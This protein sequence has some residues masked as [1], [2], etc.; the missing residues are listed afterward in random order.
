MPKLIPLFPHHNHYV[1]VFGGS[2]AD[3]LAKPRS[4][5]ETYNDLDGQLYEF[6]SAI[7]NPAQRNVLL[8][9]LRHTPICQ[10]T[11]LDALQIVQSPTTDSVENAW[12]FIVVSQ[13]GMCL[14]HP[15]LLAPRNWRI[16]RKPHG[17]V[18]GWATLPQAVT[19]AAERF[20]VVQIADESWDRLIRKCDTP[21]T[22]FYL[23]PSYYP[24]TLQS[25]RS[26]YN[27][28]LSPADHAALVA[29]L[30]EIDGY[31]IL[32]GYDNDLYRQELR[33]WRRVAFEVRTSIELSGAR[34]RR[35]EIVWLN[36]DE[37]G[38]RRK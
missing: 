34:R 38:I 8:D 12:A 35:E 26:F 36:F 24:E 6:F 10:R 28:E 30:N 7:Q 5:L 23:D 19:S 9:R 2:G 21:E 11:F 13:Q 31:A 29:S 22:L 17:V 3:I 25:E 1:S 32:S 4:R 20:R 15:A 18:K 27:H 37:N 16:I 14:S 33:H